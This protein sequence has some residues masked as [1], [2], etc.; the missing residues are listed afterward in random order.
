MGA[1]DGV[2]M[3]HIAAHW[4]LVVLFVTA[5]IGAVLSARSR[6]EKTNG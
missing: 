4:P 6:N 3:M 2:S 1:K 5:A